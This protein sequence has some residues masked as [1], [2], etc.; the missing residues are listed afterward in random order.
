M[1]LLEVWEFEKKVGWCQ[2]KLFLR[3]LVPLL[4]AAELDNYVAVFSSNM[5]LPAL[6]IGSFYIS[7]SCYIATCLF[8]LITM[9]N[10]SDVAIL[11]FVNQATAIIHKKKFSHHRT[12]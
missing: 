4:V 5:P 11:E 2:P 7:E 8:V 10:S 1:M 12:S 9:I 6:F 3:F